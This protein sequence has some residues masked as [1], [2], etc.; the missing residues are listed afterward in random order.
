MAI[1]PSVQKMDDLTLIKHMEARHDEMIADGFNLSP[2]GQPIVLRAG[3]T[4]R[5]FHDKM[6][7]LYDGRV[8]DGEPFFNH[9]HKPENE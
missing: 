8:V 2:K 5:V 6:H 9:A 4:W 7:E 3:V 1:V